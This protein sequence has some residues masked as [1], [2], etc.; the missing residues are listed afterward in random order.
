MFRSRAKQSKSM[1]R[2]PPPPLPKG[3]V[4]HTGLA[5]DPA[6]PDNDTL[7]AALLAVNNNPVAK[8]EE[9]RSSFSKANPTSPTQNITYRYQSPSNGKG[10]ITAMNSKFLNRTRDKQ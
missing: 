6:S 10:R 7:H 8:H 1:K 9:R 3:N 2:K 5:K 4:G